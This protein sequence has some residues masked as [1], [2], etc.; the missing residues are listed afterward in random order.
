[1]GMIPE[2]NCRRCGET[3]SSLRSRCPN[4]GTPRQNQPN[5]V[6][7]TT[8]SATPNT[9]ASRRAGADIRWQ[10]I[11]GGILLIAVYPGHPEGT[12]EGQMLDDYFRTLSR[13]QMSISRFQIINSPQSPFFFA[14]EKK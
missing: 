14:V 8:A 4:C 10:L 3:F 2:V 6:P 1:M 12:L 11:F 13:F 9:A 5:R 7:H